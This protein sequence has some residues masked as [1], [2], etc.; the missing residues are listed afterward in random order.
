MH[1]KLTTFVLLTETELL[2]ASSPLGWQGGGGLDRGACA[3]GGR[4]LVNR[5]ARA[6]P[7][8]REAARRGSSAR[9]MAALALGQLRWTR[10]GAHR[11]L[12]LLR[13]AAR[14]HEGASGRGAEETEM[15]RLYSEGGPP[16]D[17]GCGLAR[18]GA[19]AV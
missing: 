3:A 8:A 9:R 5:V 2:T 1:V 13:P 6:L 10:A 11:H 14:S 15:Q 7:A 18:G 4:A 12:A 19:G 17:H 16:L